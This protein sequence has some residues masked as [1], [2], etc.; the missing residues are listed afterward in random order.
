[1]FVCVCVG[2]CVMCICIYIYIFVWYCLDTVNLTGSWPPLSLETPDTRRN[3]WCPQE[4]PKPHENR[5]RKPRT[6]TLIKTHIPTAINKSP[7]PTKPMQIFILQ[8]HG[9]F[10]QNIYL[11][12]QQKHTQPLWSLYMHW[13]RPH[14]SHH[15]VQEN[16]RQPNITREI[17][18]EQPQE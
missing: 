18:I 13:R 2:V 17:S 8:I 3:I 12:V 11:P 9:L 4:N 1:M 7:L 10:H 6:Y 5:R 15:P 14:L 16:L